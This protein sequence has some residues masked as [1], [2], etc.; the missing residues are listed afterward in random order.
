MDH[1]IA[2]RTVIAGAGAG[3]AASLVGECQ[4]AVT[5]EAGHPGERILGEQGRA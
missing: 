5:C 1:P 3:L 2:R 4:R